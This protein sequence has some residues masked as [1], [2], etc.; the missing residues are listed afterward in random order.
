MLKRGESY[1][2]VISIKPDDGTD[3]KKWKYGNL[4]NH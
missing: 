3:T 1:Y 4:V 2:Q